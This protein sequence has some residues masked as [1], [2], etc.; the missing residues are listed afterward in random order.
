[1]KIGKLDY[2]MIIGFIIL[3]LLTILFFFYPEYGI[4]FNFS[5][6]TTYMGT[7]GQSLSIVFTVCVIGNLLPFPTPYTF[8]IIP[9]ALAYPIF[10]W[11]IGIVASIGALIGEIVGYLIGR[12]GHEALKKADKNVKKLNAWEDLINQRPKFVMFLI[13]LFG[14]TPLNDDNVMI[15]IGLAGF[16]YKRTILSCYL[17]KLGMMMLFANGGAFGIG[18]IQSL[19]GTSEANPYGWVEGII[20]MAVTLVIIWIMFKIDVRRFLKDKYGVEEL[21]EVEE[22]EKD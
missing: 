7:F 1:M 15:P 16:D 4:L 10:F 5:T 17:G 19:A 13:F 14:L 12:G 20:V 11:L 9:A 2:I 6:W 21:E 8:I 22:E 18:W 3:G